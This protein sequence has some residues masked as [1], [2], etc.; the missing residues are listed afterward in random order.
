MKTTHL[1]RSLAAVATA[2]ACLAVMAGPASATPHDV[3]IT[4]GVIRLTKTGLTPEDIDLAPTATPSCTNPSTLQ[5]DENGTTA[6]VTSLDSSH[7]KHFPSSSSWLWVLT[8]S[9]FGNVAGA[10]DST[11]SPHTITSM[12]VGVLVTIYNT[13]G[14]TPTG[15]PIC[16]AAFS[17]QVNGT[18]TS[19]SSGDTFSLTGVSVGTIAAAPTCAAGP[20]YLIG[21]TSTVTSPITGTL[22]T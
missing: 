7:I 18:S 3:D 12:R 5:V 2:I 15:T 16:N 17:L 14:C 6:I 10:L 22:T 20:S 8:R 13:T 4:G 9:P 21:S 19:T 11:V 1:R